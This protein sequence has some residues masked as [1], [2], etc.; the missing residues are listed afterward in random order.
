MPQPGKHKF[1][2]RLRQA[3]E[4]LECHHVAGADSYLFTV[5]ALVLLPAL[6]GPSAGE[7]SLTVALG[8]TALKVGALVAF[9]ALVG[10]RERP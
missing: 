2:E 4:V 6:F 3:P 9:T 8:F 5:V 10:T 7:R 1:I